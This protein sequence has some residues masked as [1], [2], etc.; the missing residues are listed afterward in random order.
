MLTMC[1]E[2]SSTPLAIREMQIQTTTRCHFTSTRI[3]IT[4]KVRITIGSS[5]STPR[6]VP[7]QTFNRDSDTRTSIFIIVNISEPRGEKN[8]FHQLLNGWINKM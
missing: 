5:N 1:L 8:Q 6:W 7:K 2:R 3:I 4:K